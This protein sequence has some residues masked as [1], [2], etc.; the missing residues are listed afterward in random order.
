MISMNQENPSRSHYLTES[1]PAAAARTV[2]E[3]PFARLASGREGRI[4]AALGLGQGSPLPR[5]SS[6]ALRAYYQYLS[7]RLSFPF[8]AQYCSDAERIWRAVTVVGLLK[9]RKSCDWSCPGLLCLARAGDDVVELP[10]VDLELP[11]SDPNFPW[12]DDYWYWFW[13]W[14]G[15]SSE[16]R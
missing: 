8:K 15:R 3:D 5:V 12:I 9:P 11:P 1:V 4:R 13:N 7:A 2:P 10:L 16:P 14:Q 6:D